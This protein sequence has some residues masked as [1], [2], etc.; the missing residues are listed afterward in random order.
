MSP[1]HSTFLDFLDFCLP[2]IDLL[3]QSRD[4]LGIIRLLPGSREK[5]LQ[6]PDFLSSDVNLFFL[7]LVQCHGQLC[8]DR[9]GTGMEWLIIPQV[10]VSVSVLWQNTSQ[11]R[12]STAGDWRRIN[13][14]HIFCA[15]IA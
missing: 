6:I 2:V 9:Q 1:G 10:L 11:S 12:R 15:T 4:I 7:F 14:C 3:L 8:S 13:P 5:L